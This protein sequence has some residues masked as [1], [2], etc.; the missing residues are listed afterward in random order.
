MTVDKEVQ[1]SLYPSQV[2]TLTRHSQCL[3][4][5]QAWYLFYRPRKHERLREFR[6]A[7]ILGW[8]SLQISRNLIFFFKIILM[9]KMRCLIPK[10]TERLCNY[11]LL[12]YLNK[13]TIGV[14][15]N[16]QSKWK[17]KLLHIYPYKLIFFCY[18]ASI[19]FQG[20]NNIA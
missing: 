10:M 5:M 17:K 20:I 12:I 18:S 15:K 2:N 4:P 14:D 9:K 6:L 8:N 3:I 19:I 11:F 13:Y 16:V 1:C 7:G